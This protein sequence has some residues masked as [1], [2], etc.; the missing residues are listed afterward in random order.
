MDPCS[1]FLTKEHTLI[2]WTRFVPRSH[3]FTVDVRLIRVQTLKRPLSCTTSYQIF[4]CSST[5]FTNKKAA[6]LSM[7]GKAKTALLSRPSPS[8]GY[9]L[10]QT[11]LNCEISSSI[12]LYLIFTLSSTLFFLLTYSTLEPYFF[13]T[14]IPAKKA[15]TATI[16]VI[17]HSLLEEFTP[18]LGF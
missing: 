15:S 11:V 9:F 10:N 3:S 17:I 2:T 8:S 16:I 14:N 13:W 6:H 18:I 5:K 12:L 4:I 1:R 7:D